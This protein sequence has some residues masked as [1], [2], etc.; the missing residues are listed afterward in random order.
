MTDGNKKYATIATFSAADHAFK[1][2]QLRSRTWQTLEMVNQKD[3]DQLTPTGKKWIMRS[4]EY[5]ERQMRK[6]G[7]VMSNHTT[8][9]DNIDGV[10]FVSTFA[11]V[12]AVMPGDRK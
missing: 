2:G 7:V 6:F 1:V 10:C 12:L 11:T 4:E 3:I 9:V 8:L 5:W